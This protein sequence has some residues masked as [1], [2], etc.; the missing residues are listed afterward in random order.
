MKK[1]ADGA[2]DRNAFQFLKDQLEQK[3]E[4]LSK[5]KVLLQRAI[6]REKQL[7]QQVV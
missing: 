1:K 6:L 7:I 2:G 3:C 5:V 4:L